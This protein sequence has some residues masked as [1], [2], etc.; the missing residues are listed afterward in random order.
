MIVHHIPI[1]S[2]INYEEGFTERFLKDLLSVFGE[3]DKPFFQSDL[4]MM[5]MNMPYSLVELP[6]TN[7]NYLS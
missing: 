5:D 1:G 3:L 4:M 2:L 7:A 6:S